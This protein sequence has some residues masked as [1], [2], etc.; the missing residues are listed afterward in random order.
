MVALPAR[1]AGRYP[2]ELSGGQ[3]QRVAIARAL[4]VEPR[5][6]VLDEPTS[7][8]DVS[9]RAEVMNLLDPPAGGARSSRTSSSATTSAWSGTS[10][11]RSRSCTSAGSSRRGPTTS[12]STAPATRTRER[13]PQPCPCPIPSS[14][15]SAAAQA[16]SS[17]APRSGRA[18]GRLPVQPTLS[19]GR[20]RSA[21][22]VDPPLL[23]LAPAHQR[24]ATSPLARQASRR[25]SRHRTETRAAARRRADDPRDQP[26]KSALCASH[27]ADS[28]GA[29]L[30]ACAPATV[31]RTATC[32]G[33][34]YQ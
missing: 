4:A 16:A 28:C 34:S 24:P 23:E 10:A 17:R 21:S 6:L 18:R 8:L 2:H 14:R 12:C 22:R 1:F 25:R 30:G 32:D 9:V 7:A 19:A 5:I 33:S 27:Q 13:S 29:D 31:A 11:T 15:R 20:G 26:P 3:A